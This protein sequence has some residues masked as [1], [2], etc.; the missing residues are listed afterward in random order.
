M[1]TSWYQRVNSPRGGPAPPRPLP[2]APRAA[3]VRGAVPFIPFGAQRTRTGGHHA[4]KHA[5]EPTVAPRPALKRPAR[6]PSGPSS[7]DGGHQATVDDQVLP[8]DVGGLV[9]GEEGDS[10]GDVLGGAETPGDDPGDDGG[11]FLDR[12]FSWNIAVSM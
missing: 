9:R 4:R 6:G 12:H 3:A 10:V 11:L 7:R 1:Q 2:A 8:V 5:G